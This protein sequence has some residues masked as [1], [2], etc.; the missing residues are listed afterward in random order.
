MGDN[1]FKPGGL[2]SLRHD[3]AEPERVGL[4]IRDRWYSAS[5]DVLWDDGTVCQHLTR[6]LRAAW[7]VTGES[8][9]FR[10]R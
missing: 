2:V 8:R 4:V 10:R 5:L 7:L 9:E 3:Q 1:Q 6:A